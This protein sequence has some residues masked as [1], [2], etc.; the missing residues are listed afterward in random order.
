MHAAYPLL[1]FLFL[2]EGRRR[3]A[4]MW[5]PF[6]LVVWFAVVYLGHHYVIDV[7][8]GAMYAL[9]GYLLMKRLMPPDG[10]SP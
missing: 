7:F 10:R 2:W 9:A 3:L 6:V 4:T 1:V 8:G 5:A